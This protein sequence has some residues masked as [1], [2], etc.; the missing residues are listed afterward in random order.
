MRNNLHMP[1]LDHIDRKILD[2]LQLKARITNAELADRVNLSASACLR[3]V[4]DL[5][6]AGI[7][8]D[9]VA[10]LDHRRIGRCCSIFV[11]V[12]LASQAAAALAAFEAAVTRCPEVMDR[13]M[14]SGDYDYLL[15]V[16]VADAQD[17][18]RVHNH[19]LS[20]LPGVSRIRSSF[21]LRTVCRRTAFPMAVAEAPAK[22]QRPSARRRNGRRPLA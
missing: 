11:E 19:H 17:Y 4:R 5:E 21:V 7:I 8:Q 10:L 16:V 12:T 6:E 15:R 14:I 20:K 3:R 9:Y 1:G 13:A 2:L 22:P 18:E